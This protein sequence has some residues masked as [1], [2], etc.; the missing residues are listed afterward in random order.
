MDIL[1]WDSVLGACQAKRPLYRETAITIGSFDGLHRGHKKLC[2]CVLNEKKKKKVPYSSQIK[3]GLITFVRPTK[4]SLATEYQGDILSTR[5]KCAC[6]KDMGFDFI[7]LIEF[8]EDF[9]KTSGEDFFYIL[10]T[11]L[12][13]KKLCVGAD[14]ACG[15][16]HKTNVQEIQKLSTLYHFELISI[17][18]VQTKGQTVSSSRIRTHIGAG[19]CLEAKQLLGYSFMLDIKGIPYTYTNT[20]GYFFKR[21]SFLQ[22]IPHHGTYTVKL[23]IHH[24]KP[25]RAIVTID[26]THLHLQIS[27]TFYP[28]RTFYPMEEKQKDYAPL[29]EYLQFIKRRS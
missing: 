4:S 1:S 9:A 25:V 15:Y 22:V 18:P 29:F 12:G 19:N 10:H 13:L 26:D 28:F 5:L 7:V 21:R 6:I 11:A 14:F 24:S 17:M 27:P 23:F 8:T 3:A 16:Q 20:D 2:T